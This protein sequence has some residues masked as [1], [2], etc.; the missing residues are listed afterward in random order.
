MQSLISSFLSVFIVCQGNLSPAREPLTSSSPTPLS[1]EPTP[2]SHN[3]PMPIVD[4]D[5]P[6]SDPVKSVGYLDEDVGLGLDADIQDAFFSEVH[7]PTPTTVTSRDSPEPI[8]SSERHVQCAC[9]FMVT[10]Y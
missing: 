8:E 1:M 6:S 2:P 5:L 9:K 7:M 4:H 10:R 3:S